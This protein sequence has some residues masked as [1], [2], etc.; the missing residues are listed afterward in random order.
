MPDKE[1]PSKN[2]P[3]KQIFGQSHKKP[4]N[5]QYSEDL[6]DDSVQELKIQP[7]NPLPNL[8]EKEESIS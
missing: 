3:V 7:K 1:A 5:D 6:F 2:R 8:N 4:I